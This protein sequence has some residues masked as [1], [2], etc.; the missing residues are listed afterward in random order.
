MSF[1]VPDSDVMTEP[2]SWLLAA[3]A[4]APD[5]AHGYFQRP[6]LLERLGPAA[7]H[8]LV[9]VSAPGG[10]GKTTLLA[11]LC[12]RERERGVRAAWITL[13]GDDT[14][15]VLRA[16]LVHA[17]VRA[18]LAR[19]LLHAL[20]G[21]APHPHPV[22]QRTELLLR[23]IERSAA[24]WLLVLD[25]AERLRDR[26]AVGTVDFLLQQ[27][28]DNLRIAVA[29]RENPGLEVATAILAGRGVEVTAKD[30]R[31]SPAEV[32][33][34]FDGALPRRTLDAVTTRTAGWPVALRIYR[35][36]AAGGASK[37]TAA[38]LAGD[39]GVVADYCN[40]RL[41][42]GLSDEDRGLLFDLALF[43]W[44]DPALVDEVLRIG[45]ARR[46]IDALSALAGFLQPLADDT[47]VRRLHPLVR[48][49]CAARRFREDPEGFRDLHRRI[50]HALAARG[51]T[52]DALRHARDAG[53]ARLAGEILERA[54]GLRVLLRDG[55]TALRA[56]DRLL[57]PETLAT[58]PRLGLA[59]CVLHVRTARLDDARALLDDVRRAT[60]D[61]T[62]DR[63]GG[64]D[65]AL[66]VDAFI[67]RALLA[68]FGCVS[69]HSEQARR[70]LAEGHR[71][72]DDSD[73][74][75]EILGVVCEL[76]CAARGQTAQFETSRALGT[77]SAEHFARCGSR[78]GA[79]FVDLHL[80]TVAMAQG[81]AEEAAERY[82]RAR[83]T[84]AQVFT[85]DAG[86]ALFGDVLTAE[87]ALERN[88][89]SALDDRVL[90][91]PLRLRD[92]GAWFDVFAAAWGVAAELTAVRR[93]ADAAVALL[94]E[95]QERARAL[96]RAS[97]ATY[98]AALRVSVLVAAGRPERA[99]EAWR[100]G[101]L[102]GGGADLFD[103][104]VR[105]W[106]EMEALAE[107]R[108]R[109]LAGQGDLDA[110]RDL[111]GRLCVAAAER[112]LARTLMRGLAAAAAAAH[113]AGDAAGAAARA[114]EFVRLARR[115]DYPRPLVREG[116]AAA[117]VLRDLLRTDLDP[118]AR[119]AA[120]ALR[121]Q[122]EEPS[123]AP[124]PPVLSAREREVLAGTARGERAKETAARIGLTEDG[125][126]YH[127]KQ[128]YRKL[129]VSGRHDAVRR[130]QEAGIL[131]D[132]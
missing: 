7:G 90:R 107:A 56:A 20:R 5:P 70:L 105:S 71:L 31:F 83:R 14:P 15:D 65:R 49:Y 46:R 78:Q 21:A 19:S 36:A 9:V 44:I 61:F 24:P 127:L 92:T 113:R 37:L 118:A 47:G 1:R 76:L 2:P 102:P 68:G 62:R 82:A 28:P 35:N 94:D 100:A 51:R 48:D 98:L 119:A 50:A 34:F 67:A 17:F 11:D 97:V 43:E 126:R 42:R 27:A 89:A 75:P 8:R 60:D 23:A 124:A 73:L 22:E 80:G 3:K 64:D 93:G 112:G 88:D 129:D 106:R 99:A 79:M 85:R 33:R 59:R 81:R 86:P 132:V 111:A 103:L 131:Q 57:P 32:A 104:D 25:E 39:R 120:E 30:L 53:D 109:L 84:A 108:I 16:Y 96:G 114:A 66:R 54:G 41:L 125:V 72:A 95:A 18:G 29:F 13:D 101:G 45:D 91:F 122:V 58:Y 110:A 63:P 40:A 69:I 6:A 10:F 4:T 55:V 52:V 87:L 12:R 117:A 116:A 128:I 26:D 74:P 77:A 38:D 130:A 123:A 121:A 115:T